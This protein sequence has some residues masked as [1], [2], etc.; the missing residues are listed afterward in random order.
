MTA[1]D[2]GSIGLIVD[3]PGATPAPTRPV[4]PT[5]PPQYPHT[6]WRPRVVDT[7]YIDGDFHTE[8]CQDTR[9]LIE[10]AFAPALHLARAA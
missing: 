8:T 1:F 10:L 7:S 4:T 3:R 6:P 2:L 9:D 5:D